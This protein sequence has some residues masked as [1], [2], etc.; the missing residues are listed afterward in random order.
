M[1]K[2]K[3]GAQNKQGGSRGG[4]T[5]R[6]STP[7]GL[8]PTI[9]GLSEDDGWICTIC[10]VLHTSTDA[11]LLECDRCRDK[12]CIKC[13]NKTDDEYEV[14]KN[15][16]IMWFCPGCREKIEKNIITERKIEELCKEMMLNYEQ[17]ICALEEEIKNKCSKEDVQKIV[18]ETLKEIMKNRPPAEIDETRETNPGMVESLITEVNERKTRENNIVFFGISEINSE[19]KEE[20]TKRDIKAVKEVASACG[21]NFEDSD[22]QHTRRLG[23][24]DPGKMKR[25]LLVTV[26][27]P[28][29]KRE[30]FKTAHKIKESKFKDVRIAN[31]LTKTERDKERELFNAAKRMQEEDLSGN[32]LYR[33]RGPPWARKVIKIRKQ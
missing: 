24:Y 32:F 20:R 23:K 1:P 4:S 17:R 11:K 22:V 5:S 10:S 29:R 25:P 2:A 15:P 7:I 21:V 26:K 28:D 33:V 6:P 16:D 12:F 3:G 9:L 18:S 30:L 31:D 19:I 14:M 27:N 8:D 13:L